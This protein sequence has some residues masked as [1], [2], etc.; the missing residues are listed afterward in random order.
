MFGYA[1][2]SFFLAP[3]IRKSLNS[4]VFYVDHIILVLDAF[5]CDG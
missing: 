1:R 5:E 2:S 3:Y 4:P